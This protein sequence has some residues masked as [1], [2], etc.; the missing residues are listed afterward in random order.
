[1]SRGRTR[2]QE[3]TTSRHLG[4][5]AERV[6]AGA[7]VV[8]RGHL[9]DHVLLDDQ[10]VEQ[11]WA[12]SRVLNE[13]NGTRWLFVAN[14][15]DGTF[16]AESNK[17]E[18]AGDFFARI[19]PV[20]HD[21]QPRLGD[22]DPVGIAE[23]VRLLLRQEENP[24]AV[25]LE[26][27]TMLFGSS[28]RDSRL[29][30]GILCEGVSEAAFFS[31][32]EGITPHNTLIVCGVP[33]GAAVEAIAPLPGVEEMVIERPNHDERMSALRDLRQG[34][35]RGGNG[36]RP[37]HEDLDVLANMTDGWSLQAICGLSRASHALR[38]PATRP[39]TLYRRSRG[40]STLTPLGKVGIK[41]IMGQLESEVRGQTETFKEVKERLELG[42]W[43][44]ANRARGMLATRPMATIVMHGPPG[45]GKT[46]TALILA[47]AVLGSRGALRR[48]DCSE[49][50][51]AHDIARLTGAPPGYVGYSEGGA[52][53][54]ALEQ[55][56]AVILFDEFDRAHPG[57]NE[58]LL[59]ILDAGRLTDGRGRTA[60]FENAILL[61]TTNLGFRE[62][63][64]AVHSYHDVPPRDEFVEDN[65]KRLKSVIENGSEDRLGNVRPGS[66]AL[67]SRLQSAVI[68]YDILR[69]D[70]IEEIITISCQRLEANLGDE[71]EL[72]LVLVAEEFAPRLAAKAMENEKWDGRSVYSK[73]QQLIES[74]VRTKLEE[75]EQRERLA[76]GAELHFSPDDAGRAVLL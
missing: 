61:F 29:A 21:R 40:E 67:W 69:A 8:L 14:Q 36:G 55:D 1:L 62:D 31:R 64:G 72:D 4:R 10:I 51:N 33:D 19:P 71:L 54:E 7:H 22:N 20:D 48:I 9:R 56:A 24:V 16:C 46:E 34:F 2:K 39:E 60:T 47:E 15:A 65:A 6:R 35:Y 3:P 38:A 11:S 44:P 50:R 12:M 37:S 17:E 58:T 59:G 49:M 42:C 26:D 13:R 30:L 25:L 73:V 32:R 52:L 63:E 75:L 57:L 70:A 66:P 68:G 41:R 27:P 76:P 43:R 53:T 18:A 28:D 5:L 23:T 45:V 74:P